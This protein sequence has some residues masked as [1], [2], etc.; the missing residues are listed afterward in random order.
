M[1]IICGN[2]CNEA[3]ES[4][5]FFQIR[6]TK[7]LIMQSSPQ[8]QQQVGGGVWNDGGKPFCTFHTTSKLTNR[9]FYS[10]DG[11]VCLYYGAELIV[12]FWYGTSTG[13]DN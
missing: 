8:Q 13:S 12:G 7:W 2:V 10:S 4:L 6:A 9:S 11:D 1:F 5:F 3:N